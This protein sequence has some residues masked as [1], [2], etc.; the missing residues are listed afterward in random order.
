MKK[1]TAQS[2]RDA[3]RKDSTSKDSS[4]SSKDAKATKGW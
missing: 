3:A 2:G 4:S 1:T